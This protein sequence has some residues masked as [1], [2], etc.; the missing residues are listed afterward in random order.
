MPKPITRAAGLTLEQL[1]ARTT[2][3]PDGTKTVTRQGKTFTMKTAKIG[4][5]APLVGRVRDSLTVTGLQ[6]NER[7]GA[8]G[9]GV[10]SVTGLQIEPEKA[11]N[12]R[13][14]GSKFGEI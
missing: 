6:S 12:P 14:R 3:A 2:R 8:D 13:A 10:L 11:R 4:V 1:A 5:G 7:I 9:R